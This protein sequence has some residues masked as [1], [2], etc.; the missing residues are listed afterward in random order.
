MSNPEP[1]VF[2]YTALDA[3][4]R[5]YVQQK[6]D[7]L[8]GQLQRT[9]QA[10]VAIGQNL[11]AVK[12][13]LPHGAFLPWLQQE[14]GMTRRTA[15]HF[16]HVAT[17]F[18]G[19]WEMISHLPL[20]V[21]YELAS[22]STSD[23]IVAQVE[24]HTLPATLPAIQEAKQA[25]R[26]ARAQAA[27]AEAQVTTLQQELIVARADSLQAQHT[28]S[29][30]TDELT[31]LHQQI[32]QGSKQDRAP[33]SVLSEAAQLQMST[34][35]K[36]IE[37]V[38]RQRDQLFTENQ[39]YAE[40]ARTHLPL[41]MHEQADQT[42]R[43]SWREAASAFR[44]AVRS[45]LMQWPSG[46]DR[47]HLEAEDWHWM[48]DVLEDCRRVLKESITLYEHQDSG[49]VDADEMPPEQGGEV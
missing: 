29:R 43:L 44:A 3:D 46:L 31:S 12:A 4:T 34:L 19:K 42:R 9:T 22:P 33:V 39:A 8:H 13:R 16:M 10:V 36:Q 24:E 6:T 26:E 20:A 48:S 45:L 7:E 25:E 5:A 41:T 35:T 1:T 27:E 37:Q 40:E 14:F 11:L 28:V 15:V 21:L 38:T 17:R 18:A 49:V 32:E 47:A 30:L 2:E 23:A